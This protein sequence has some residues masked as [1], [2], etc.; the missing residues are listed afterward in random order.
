MC[1]KSENVVFE[2][3][4]SCLEYDGSFRF[5]F[6]DVGMENRQSYAGNAERINQ[7][8]TIEQDRKELTFFIILCISSREG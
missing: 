4:V 1:L 3:I 5:R 6:S 8:I 2:L 7:Q